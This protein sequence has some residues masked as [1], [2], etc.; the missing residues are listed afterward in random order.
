MCLILQ[1]NRALTQVS[2][3]ST[4]LNPKEDNPEKQVAEF[5]HFLPVISY[6]GGSMKRFDAGDILDYT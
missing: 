4:K 3:Y 5:I 1:L 2:D 6:D